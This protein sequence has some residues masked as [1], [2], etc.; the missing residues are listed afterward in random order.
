[1]VWYWWH[2]GEIRMKFCKVFELETG[3]QVLFMI[4][5]DD[6]DNPVVQSI[7]VI[8]HIK[9]ATGVAFKNMDE[10]DAEKAAQ[11]MLDGLNE[12]NARGYFKWALDVVGGD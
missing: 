11:K 10:D 7:T 8:D 1:M 2:N 3:H 6:Q 4:T 9:V 12:E 5:E